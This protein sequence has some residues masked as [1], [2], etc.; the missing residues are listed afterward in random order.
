MALPAVKHM[1]PVVGIDVHS[2]IVTPGLPPVFLP[3]PHV[4]FM[5]D[6]REYV[7]AAK[8]V[9][10]SIAMTIA[11]DAVQDGLPEGSPR[12][13]QETDRCAQFAR[14]PEEAGR[15]RSLG[16]AGAEARSRSVVNQG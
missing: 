4:G 3:H 2:V 5:L 13:R 8:G 9:I 1:D 10:G 12:R 6:L 7:E 11:E 15:A 14:E 16:R